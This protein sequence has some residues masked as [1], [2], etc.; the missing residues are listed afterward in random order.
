MTLSK[1]KCILF[2]QI[3]ATYTHGGAV[4]GEFSSV[5]SSSRLIRSWPRRQEEKRQFDF[6]TKVETEDCGVV[7][8]DQEQLRHL[9]EKVNDFKLEIKFKERGTETAAE[10]E[11]SGSLTDK[12]IKLEI[13]DGSENFMVGGFPYTGEFS[14]TLRQKQHYRQHATLVV[15]LQSISSEFCC[16]ILSHT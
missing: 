11:W 5:F 1:Y 7:S 10:D 16:L 2:P 3:C 12:A 4:K 8:I 6:T 14:V 9:T 13:K 15:R